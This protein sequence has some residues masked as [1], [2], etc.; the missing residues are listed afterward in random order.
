MGPILLHG[1]AWLQI[2]QPMFQKLNELGYKVLPHLPFSPNL[3]PTDYHFF[4][5]LN[6]FLQGKCFH[7][8][9]EAGNASQQL[10]EFLSIDFYTT[11]INLFLIGKNM[12]IVMVPI[13]INKDAFEPSYNG[14]KFTVWNHS[15]FFVPT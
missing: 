11:G 9:Q 8:Q 7:N 13:L 5:H 14:L 6:N 3:L 10:I 12:L 4:K 1:N 15:F 2:T